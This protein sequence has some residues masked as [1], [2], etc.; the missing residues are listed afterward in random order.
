MPVLKT[1]SPQTDFENPI[2]RPANLEPSSST[3]SATL[4]ASSTVIARQRMASVELEGVLVV[5][6]QR[7]VLLFLRQQ[8]VSDRE[9]LDLGAHE[10]AERLLGAADDR[11]AAHIEAGV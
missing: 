8:A 6:L 1:T 7:R 3:S 9:G 5:L 2:C 11:L 10:A 4:C